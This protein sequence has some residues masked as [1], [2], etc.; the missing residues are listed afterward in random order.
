MTEWNSLSY[1]L[2]S[3][4]QYILP[5]DSPWR[6]E[7]NSFLRWA[8]DYVGFVSTDVSPRNISN[9]YG[10]PNKITLE[11]QDYKGV[12]S[13]GNGSGSGGGGGVPPNPCGG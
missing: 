10:T 7:A 5:S 12:V 8:S 3:N 13:S 4:G 2:A 11:D 9:A 6:S 1:A